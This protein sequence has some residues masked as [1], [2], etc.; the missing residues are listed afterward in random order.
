MGQGEYLGKLGTFDLSV[1]FRIFIKAT[2]DYNDIITFESFTIFFPLCFSS[3]FKIPKCDNAK[4][5]LDSNLF[6]IIIWKIKT[7]LHNDCYRIWFEFGRIPSNSWESLRCSNKTPN[8]E[9]GHYYK[10]M[11]KRNTHHQSIYLHKPSLIKRLGDCLRYID[12][13]LPINF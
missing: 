4:V 7:I 5:I 8:P 13:P 1:V 2:L 6:L 12:M 10:L 11:E 3:S 9:E